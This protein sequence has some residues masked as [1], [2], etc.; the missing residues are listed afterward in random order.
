M[1]HNWDRDRDLQITEEEYGVGTE[2]WYGADYDT[3][4]TDYDADGSGYIDR[5]EFGGRWDNDY[6][7]RWDT[8]GDFPPTEDEYG[9]GIYNSAD[10]DQNKVI[11]VEE[12]GWFEGWFDGDNVEAEIEEVGD[13]L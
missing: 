11:T 7:S 5:N 2:R 1:F 9:T 10:L 6:Y 3:P 12:E 4:F 8:D 13:V